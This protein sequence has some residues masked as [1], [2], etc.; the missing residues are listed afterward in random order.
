MLVNCL[1]GVVRVVADYPVVAYSTCL[2]YTEQQLVYIV[3]ECPSHGL[4]V[5]FVLVSVSDYPHLLLYPAHH[6]SHVQPVKGCLFRLKGLLTF[7]HNALVL[8]DVEEVP[9]V[10]VE[11][12][13]LRVVLLGLHADVI[14]L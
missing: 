7:H 11:K 13:V 9:L 5:G 2:L 12:V 14:R 4:G 10:R 8:V 1:N 3:P 6:P